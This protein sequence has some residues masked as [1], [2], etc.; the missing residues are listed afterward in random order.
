[1]QTSYKTQAGLLKALSR[2]SESKEFNYKII[3][4]LH[5]AVYQL[6]EDFGWEE[7]QAARYVA[8]YT[9]HVEWVF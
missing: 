9:P 7:K 3:W 1:M 2:I 5:N 8:A 6:V 4:F